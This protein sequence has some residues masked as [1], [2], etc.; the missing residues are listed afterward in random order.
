MLKAIFI[1]MP[2]L[3]ALCLSGCTAEQGY[4]TAQ[5]WQ[6]SQCN[7]LPDKTEF[8]RCMSKTDTTYESYKRQREPE[9]K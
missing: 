5:A 1:S 7:Q 6:R 2:L 9:Q 8:D 3:A 4:R